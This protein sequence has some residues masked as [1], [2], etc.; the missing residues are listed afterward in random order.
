FRKMRDAGILELSASAASHGL[1]PLLSTN[2]AAARAQVLIGC[3]LYSKFFHAEP[4][5]FWLPECAFAPGLEKVLQ[6]AE[7]R[8]FILDAHAF[9]LAKPRPQRGI[10]APCFTGDGPAAFVRDPVSSRQVWSAE[11]GYPGESV[12]RDFYRDIGF[13]LPPEYVFFDTSL[14]IPRFTGLKYHRI[15]ARGPEKEIYQRTWAESAARAHAEHFLASRLRQLE[16]LHDSGF[17]PILTMPFDAE[18]FGHWWYEGPVFL[19]HFIRSAAAQSAEVQLTT[20]SDYLEKHP[21]QE[22]IAP[23]AS[24]WGEH[25][26]LK[27]WLDE[28]NAWIYPHLHAAARRM[29]E[30]ARQYRETAD[31]L[32]E[33]VLRQLARELLLMQASDWA[34]LIRN[35]TAPD[36]AEARVRAHVARFDQLY[37][38]LKSAQIDE[39]FLS[40]CESRDNLYPD[41]EWRF[42]L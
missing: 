9:A 19:E 1:L 24:S 34:F 20:P 25:G 30:A 10:Y 35:G 11:I 13:D 12:Y 17:A 18:L 37:R 4:R 23:A 39:A 5:G 15:T 26:H 3:E 2:P 21:T 7:V 40:D 38:Q 31:P 36:Y 27:V 16:P 22:V 33:R 6:E 32:V 29:Q 8:W 28:S 42:Y 14:R 41:L